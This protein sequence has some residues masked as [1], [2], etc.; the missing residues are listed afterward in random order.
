MPQLK[1]LCF[2]LSA[3]GDLVVTT[4]VYRTLSQRLGAEVHVLTKAGPGQVLHHNPYIRKLHVLGSES[5]Q[6][7]KREKFDVFVDLHGNLRSHGWRLR[8]GIPAVGFRKRNF[9]KSL[10]PRGIDVLSPQ[11]LVDRY[12]EAFA[13]LGISDDGAGLDYFVQPAERE[14]A[15]ALN[16]PEGYVALVLGATYRTKRMPV[17]LVAATIRELR[18]PVVLLGGKDV[19]ELSGEVERAV[20]AEAEPDVELVNLCDELSLRASAAV[21]DGA[22]GVIAGDTGLMHLAAALKRPTV[23]VWGST[24]PAIGMYPRMPA[25][26]ESLRRDARVPGLACQ[27]CSRIGYDACPRGHF[28]CMHDQSSAAIA[29]QLEGAIATAESS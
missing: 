5:Y 24:A 2:R 3:I 10:L 17:A 15:N 29:E 21:L 27:P 13:P 6:N 9:E 23:V 20:L 18:R 19:L 7:L 22:R 16:L 14:E 11:H 28:R 4:P 12:F 1:V 8:L 26:L 25:G